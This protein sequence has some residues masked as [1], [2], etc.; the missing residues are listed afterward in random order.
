MK[1][2]TRPQHLPM[3]P[4]LPSLKAKGVNIISP[5]FGYLLTT[6]PDNK[7]IIPSAYATTAKAAGLD[8]VASTFDR[9]GPLANVA[10]SQEYY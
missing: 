7:T 5:P 1:T 8:I 9:S 6:T 10:K 2:E 3:T 4:H